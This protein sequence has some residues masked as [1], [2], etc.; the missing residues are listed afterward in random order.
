MTGVPDQRPPRSTRTAGTTAATGTTGATRSRPSAD[1]RRPVR[2]ARV[3]LVA[4][5][6]GLSLVAACGSGSPTAGPGASA[7]G[8]ATGTTSTPST[9]APATAD[10]TTTDPTRTSGSGTNG[11]PTTP[12]PASGAG[13]DL[14]ALAGRT[15]AVDPGHN[16]QDYAHQAE[17]SRLVPA[18]GFTKPCDSGGTSTDAGYLEATFNFAVASDLRDILTAAGAKVVMT[19]T[20]NDSWGPCVDQ[21]AK[22]GNDAHADAAIA[23]HADGAAA[24][25]RGFHVISVPAGGY[26]GAIAGPSGR[27]A[28]DIRDA[29][30]A[31]SGEPVSNYVGTDGLVRRS[32]LGGLNLSTVPKVLIECANMRNAADAARLV[33][34]A[35]QHRAAAAM[36]VGLAAFLAGR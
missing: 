15:I 31:G 16:G 5:A 36:A 1:R 21:R 13:G 6:L 3:T 23:I 35:W 19:R 12:A 24:G 27:L 29:F 11:P 32:D 18:G 30:G 22:V 2:R 9:A 4:L 34:P 25:D 26:A 8:E 10:P 33:D 17:I 20:D 14:A 28:V 7:D